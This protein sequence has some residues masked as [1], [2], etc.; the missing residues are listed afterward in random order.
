MVEAIRNVSSI[1]NKK[2]KKKNKEET[3]NKDFMV[4]MIMKRNL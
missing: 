4:K 2:N 3:F 1:K